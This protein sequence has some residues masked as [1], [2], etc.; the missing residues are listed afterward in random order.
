MLFFIIMSTLLNPSM[1]NVTLPY[2]NNSQTIHNKEIN[3]TVTKE[4]IY[5]VDNIQ[6]GYEGL[7]GYLRKELALHPK[8]TIMLRI[9]N[10]LPIQDL[11]NVLSLGSKL[12]A[13]IALATKKD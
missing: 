5:F 6:V 4:L 8:A 7:E 3:L 12:N 9:D 11:V 2:S 10:T 1:I 13:K